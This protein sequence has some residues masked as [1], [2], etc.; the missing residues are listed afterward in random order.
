M[1]LGRATSPY[2]FVSWFAWAP[3]PD[4]THRVH[5]P[6]LEPYASMTKEQLREAMIDARGGAE[7]DFLQEFFLD[8]CSEAER[9]VDR[10]TFLQAQFG[11]LGEDTLLFL[12]GVAG[13]ATRL[14]PVP[15]DRDFGPRSSF[16]VCG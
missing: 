1:S 4:R 11:A 15:N 6:F 7:W 13:M 16:L 14:A 3:D 5:N 8:K 10:G 2:P 12:S 9:A